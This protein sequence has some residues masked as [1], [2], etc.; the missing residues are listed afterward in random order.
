MLAQLYA[1]FV[2]VGIGLPQPDLGIGFVAYRVGSSANSFAALRSVVDIASWAIVT[3]RGS[4]VVGACAFNVAAAVVTL[5]RVR[6]IVFRARVIASAALR[7]FGTVASFAIFTLVGCRQVGAFASNVTAAAVFQALVDIFAALRSVVDIPSCAIFT[8][9]GS[10][11]VGAFACAVAAAVVCRALVD[12]F[13]ALRSV[14]G[15]PS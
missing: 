6:L 12:I 5:A 1:L 14:V 9:G 15:I 3:F 10:R 11:R 7:S 4:P 2:G 13:A 8:L